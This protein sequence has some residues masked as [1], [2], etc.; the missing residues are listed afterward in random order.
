[1]R[2]SVPP[3]LSLYSL[4]VC[5]I[6]SEYRYIIIKHTS[7]YLPTY[8]LP[9]YLPTYTH[10][11]PPTH[12]PSYPPTYLPTYISTCLPMALQ[13]FRPWRFFSFLILHTVGRTPWTVDQSVARPL[14]THRTTQT[15]NK[16]TQASMP[17]VGF[18]STIPV[19]ERAKTVH[20]LDLAA[21]VSGTPV[22]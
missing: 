14:P 5:V 2:G 9:I 7:S 17:P 20:A 6:S 10:T 18:E 15:Q 1:M 13:P 21:T 8:H 3:F 22:G 19:F 16:R 11:H 12:L 4:T